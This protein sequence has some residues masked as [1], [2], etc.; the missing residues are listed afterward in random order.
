MRKLVLQRLK[1]RL[2]DPPLLLARGGLEPVDVEGLRSHYYQQDTDAPE[3]A[4]ALDW[5]GT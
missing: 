1:S 3:V 2:G 5:N 4:G